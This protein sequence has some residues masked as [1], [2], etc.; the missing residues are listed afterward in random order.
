MR[1]EYHKKLTAILIVLALSIGFSTI[2]AFAQDTVT[3]SG[4]FTIIWGDSKDESSMIY[5]L[6]D[7]NGQRTSLRMDETVVKEL[8]GVLQFN[9]EYVAVQGSMASPSSAATSLDTTS[10]SDSSAGPG[11]AL[12]VIS[13]YFSA[14]PESLAPK[15]EA[16]VLAVSGSNPWVTIMCKFSDITA[17]PNDVAFFNGMYSDTKPGLNHY[18]KE[19]SFNIANVSGSGVGGTGWYDLPNPEIHYNPT[20]TEKGTD[21]TLLAQECID[22]VDADDD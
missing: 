22:A 3:R 11:K 14:P 2:T 4:W 18:W 1:F 17:E 9:R 15:M 6:T 5:T 10:S 13:I 20:D 12:N 16:T 19:L 21:R 8:G 7:E